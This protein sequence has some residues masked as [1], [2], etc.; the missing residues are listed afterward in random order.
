M[1]GNKKPNDLELVSTRQGYQRFYTTEIK[2]LVDKLEI[3]E[4]KLKDAMS[5]FLT[6]I[7]GKFHDKKQVWLQAVNILTELDSLASLSIV[8]G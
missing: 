8:S 6:A 5:P 1:R 3:A 4:D 7:F 2:A